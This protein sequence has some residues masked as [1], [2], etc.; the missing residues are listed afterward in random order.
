MG[1]DYY[2]C[3]ICGEIFNDCG[4]FGYCSNC[5]EMLCGHCHDE[6]IEKHGNPEEGSEAASDYGEGSAAKCD[7]CSGE[8]IQD[9]DIIQW[10]VNETGITE[11]EVIKLIKESIKG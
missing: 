1:V 10:F 3:G 5:G 4:Y 11:E 9:H 2:N 6:Q 7:I 8:I